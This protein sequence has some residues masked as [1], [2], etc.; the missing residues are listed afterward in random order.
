MVFAHVLEHTVLSGSRKFEVKDVFNEISKGGLTTFLNAMTSPDTT[1][2][3][4][5]TRNE[6]EYFNIMDVY[7][8]T[9]FFQN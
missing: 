8:D 7:M 2:Y 3:P 6:K 5:A 4:F 1:F 9:T